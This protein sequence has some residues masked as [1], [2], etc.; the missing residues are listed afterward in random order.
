[1]GYPPALDRA[2]RGTCGRAIL[3]IAQFRRCLRETLCRCDARRIAGICWTETARSWEGWPAVLRC[4]TVCVARSP[5][6]TP[7]PPGT[8]RVRRR[9][10]RTAFAA[11]LG[12]LWCRS[13]FLNLIRSCLRAIGPIRLGRRWTQRRL[14]VWEVNL[15]DHVPCLHSEPRLDTNC[16]V[17]T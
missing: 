4:P 17:C 13:W 1:M 14:L 6:S 8:A 5:S 15:D 11:T 10:T 2:S 7:S 3:C 12:R 9:S 16:A